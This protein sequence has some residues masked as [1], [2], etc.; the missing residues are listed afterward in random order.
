MILSLERIGVSG[1]ELDVAG[2][3]ADVLGHADHFISIVA[4]DPD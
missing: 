1:I 2:L 3:I 4:N